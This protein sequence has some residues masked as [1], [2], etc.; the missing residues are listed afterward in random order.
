MFDRS[1]LGNKEALQL[2]E[3]RLGLLHCLTGCNGSSCIQVP[4]ASRAAAAGSSEATLTAG[5]ERL[6]KLHEDTSKVHAK[7]LQLVEKAE[8]KHEAARSIVE[9]MAGVMALGRLLGP[10]V[11]LQTAA[12]ASPSCVTMLSLCCPPCYAVR[13]CQGQSS[14]QTCYHKGLVHRAL[15]DDCITMTQGKITPWRCIL[16]TEAPLLISSYRTKSSGSVCTVQS[17]H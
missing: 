9:E 7:I 2:Q 5:I 14:C 11:S 6:M 1:L 15:N 10:H 12:A 8:R 16:L 3:P 17:D 4:S 13:L